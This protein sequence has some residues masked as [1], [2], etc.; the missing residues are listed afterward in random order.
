M[1]RLERA[2]NTKGIKLHG[3]ANSREEEAAIS[4]TGKQIT[5]ATPEMTDKKIAEVLG[6]PHAIDSIITF[7]GGTQYQTPQQ[8]AYF[9]EL[10]L[11]A[12][13]KLLDPS[14][15]LVVAFA[16]TN[17]NDGVTGSVNTA[18]RKLSDL[19]DNNLISICFVPE[20]KSI[21]AEATH[22]IVTEFDEAQ[23]AKEKLERIRQQIE[24]L[25]KYPKSTDPS[26]D[27]KRIEAKEAMLSPRPW[28]V[29][30]QR[31]DTFTSNLG[32]EHTQKTT[33]LIGGGWIS[34]Y[35]LVRKVSK[36]ERV[37]VITPTGGIADVVHAVF[38]GS[39]AT[40]YSNGESANNAVMLGM[41]YGRAYINGD[42]GENDRDPEFLDISSFSTPQ[43]ASNALVSMI[44]ASQ[45]N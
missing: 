45:E 19:P 26:K 40:T 35:E 2:K 14:H 1:S 37:I 13:G 7:I 15:N 33:I 36:G 12:L 29:A 23:E 28:H 42:L 22:V 41:V 5:K 9:D 27:T 43:E 44:Q 4:S 8:K 31:L 25:G 38:P 20:N 16:G 34:A 3:R 10:I 6:L 39:T 30:S 18:I 11:A 17:D 24:S 21:P 32:N